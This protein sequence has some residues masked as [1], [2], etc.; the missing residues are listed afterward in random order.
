[1]K[2]AIIVTGLLSG[3]AALFYF[4]KKEYD[5]LSNAKFRVRRIKKINAI[6]GITTINYDLEIANESNIDITFKNLK[7]DIF[8]G[9]KLIGDVTYNRN[10]FVPAKGAGVVPLE[11]KINSRALLESI[12][13]SITQLL[14]AKS[15]SLTFKIYVD[16][17]ALGL[18]INKLTFEDTL[19]EFK[20]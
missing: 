9:S 2:K 3:I 17:K 13:G 11:S 1:M 14:K 18:T 4:A 5:L 16:I 7:I 20:I 10:I 6:G 8:S 19:K 15:I 12:V